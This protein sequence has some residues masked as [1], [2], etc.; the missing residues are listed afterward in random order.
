MKETELKKDEVIFS[1]SHSYNDLNVF[2][3]NF[4]EGTSVPAKKQSSLDDVII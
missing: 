4:G 2:W 3:I 1:R